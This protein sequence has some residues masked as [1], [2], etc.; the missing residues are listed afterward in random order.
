IPAAWLIEQAGWKDKERD[1]VGVYPQQALVIVN[2]GGASGHQILELA[3]N[4]QQSVSE[5]F[6]IAL[7]REVNV[8]GNNYQNNH[9]QR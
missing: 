9:K 6:D 4:I 7:E 2:K 1:K 3:N 5:R 8:I